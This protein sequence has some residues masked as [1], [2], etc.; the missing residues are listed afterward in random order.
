M[1]LHERSTWKIN[2]KICKDAVAQ[3]KHKWSLREG[4]EVR[5]FNEWENMVNYCIRRR[6][7]FSEESILIQGNV[8]SNP[9]N[10]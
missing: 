3:C 8:S 10:I 9:G 5:A 7:R 6:V 1:N 2:E 4:V